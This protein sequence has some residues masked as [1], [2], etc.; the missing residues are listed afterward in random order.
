MGQNKE[1]D[2]YVLESELK[3]ELQH[4]IQVAHNEQQALLNMVV[5]SWE[6]MEM[7]KALSG[8]GNPGDF[9]QV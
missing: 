8:G 1:V 3:E 2:C 6:D 5:D 7:M 4:N 9:E